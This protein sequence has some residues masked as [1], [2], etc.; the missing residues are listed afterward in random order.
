MIGAASPGGY[1]SDPGVLMGVCMILFGPVVVWIQC[2]Y[3]I[4]FFRINSTLTEIKD[5]LR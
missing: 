1:G 3:L 2:D 5:K 4:V